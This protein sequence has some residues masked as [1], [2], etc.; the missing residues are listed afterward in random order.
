[1]TDIKN[2]SNLLYVAKYD[3]LDNFENPARKVGITGGGSSTGSSR[4]KQLS[5]GTE[6]YSP[7]FAVQLWE[8][9]LGMIAKEAEDYIH[10]S[11]DIFGLRTNREWFNG[12]S[13]ENNSVEEFVELY[14]IDLQRRGIEVKELL[15]GIPEKAKEK[16]ILSEDNEKIKVRGSKR[17]LPKIVTINGE[18][19][20]Y[21]SFVDIYRSVFRILVDKEKITKGICPVSKSEGNKNYLINIDSEHSDESPFLGPYEYN[22][23]YLETHGSAKSMIDRSYLLVKRF[24][25]NELILNIK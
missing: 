24:G 8:F 22:E 9:P 17:P 4:M 19:L 14:M 16:E 12:G 20:Q 23:I 11:L 18:S 1:M 10:R 21:S 3:D 2:K 5:S 13:S 25:N 7:I 15:E 6:S